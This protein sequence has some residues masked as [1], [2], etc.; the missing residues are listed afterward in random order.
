MNDSTINNNIKYI[1]KN[2]PEYQKETYLGIH[3][4]DSFHELNLSNVNRCCVVI[5]ID[6]MTRKNL[7]HWVVAMKLNKDLYFLDSFA[8]HP[9]FYN[10][11]I[12]NKYFNFSYYLVKRLQAND[13]TSCG[14]YC[15]FFI[16][17]ILR[18][19][20]NIAR[21]ENILTSTFFSNHYK[22]NDRNI[23]EY[24]FKNTSIS[25]KKCKEYFCNKDFIIKHKQC[26]KSVCDGI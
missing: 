26:S 2:N 5:F 9:S 25:V 11:N 8:K 23:A 22:K 13:S 14:A 24:V 3:S 4:I 1:F 16:H 12:N 20:Y 10:K 19:E 21:L 7:G 18:S 17:S 15:I 6:N